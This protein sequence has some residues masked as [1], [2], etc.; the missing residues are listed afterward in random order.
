MTEKK[1]NQKNKTKT[2][3]NNIRTIFLSKGFLLSIYLYT[4]Y[5]RWL[6][7]VWFICLKSCNELSPF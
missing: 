5:N 6:L 1:N 3:N 7:P 2:K 4:K